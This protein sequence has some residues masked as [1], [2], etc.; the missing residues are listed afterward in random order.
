MSPCVGGEGD[1]PSDP[2]AP[3]LANA[4]NRFR[5]DLD[6]N[7]RGDGGGGGG[8]GEFSSFSHSFFILLTP[9]SGKI[10]DF[11]P[12]ALPFALARG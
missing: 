1:F 3:L 12:R 5:R 10:L 11:L 4:I 8:G 2:G 6:R 9:Q 7:R